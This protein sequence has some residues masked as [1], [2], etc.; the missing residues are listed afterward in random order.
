[1]ARD[2]V[3]AERLAQEG[4]ELHVAASRQNPSLIDAAFHN[5]GDFYLIDSVSDPREVGSVAVQAQADLFL[6][7]SDEALA[8]GV[9]DEVKRLKPSMLIA[10]PDRESARIEWDKLQA[11]QLIAVLDAE[12]GTAY[13]PRFR[14]VTDFQEVLCAVHYFAEQEV[15][16][17]VKPRG[18]TGGKGVKVM[19]PH[20][21]DYT[22]AKD[23]ALEVLA[24]SGHQGLMLEEKLTGHEF[25]IQGFTDG[26]ALIAP[27]VTYDY[28][29]RE[30]GDEGPGTGGMGSFTMPPGETLPFLEDG[31]YLEALDVMRGVLAKQ[32]EQGHDFKGVLYGSFFKTADG[33][34][35]T[36]FNARIGDPEGV[37][38]VELMSDKNRLGN[39]LQGIANGTL[40]ETSIQF[41]EAASTAV[42]LVAPEY[43]YKS[44]D[45]SHGFKL[46]MDKIA[47]SG[48][49][50][51]FGAAERSDRNHYWTTGSSRVVAL[52]SRAST[53]WEARRKIHEAIQQ[54]VEGPL[55][56]RQDVGDH[57]YI[58]IELS[59]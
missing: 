3:V 51:Y 9:V 6:T 14:F 5:G 53:P 43:G 11:R 23:Y 1:M 57:D 40:S 36:E 44:G 38:I 45:H 34:K 13:N 25:T 17:V 7:N 29:Y 20:L 35:V 37:N 41:R 58:R 55:Q 18:L 10:S 22:A 48:C 46:D 59:S 15:P 49:R 54:G 47:A 2:A 19:G 26:R 4:C 39:V 24:Q 31:D 30:D 28:P 8:S 21:A 56:Y 16:I 42:Y 32:R 52:A 27:P 12:L 50:A 33:L